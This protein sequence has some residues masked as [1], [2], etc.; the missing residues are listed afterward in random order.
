MSLEPVREFI[1]NIPLN[2]T[3]GI[4]ITA[5]TRD[6]AT[7]TL[8]EQPAHHNHIATPHAAAIFALAEAASGACVGGA[9]AEE[10]GRL[11]PLAKEGNIR[12]RKVARGDLTA[13]ARLV[14]PLADLLAALPSSEK[15]VEA[16]VEVVVTD[17]QGNEATQVTMTWFLKKAV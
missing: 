11:T 14:E 17:A 13:K 10:M 15:G 7:A 6:S 1:Q 3:M 16:H 4:E 9:F 5:I 12:Y 2:K 8:R